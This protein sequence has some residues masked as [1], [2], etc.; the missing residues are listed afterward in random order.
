M[1]ISFKSIEMG[2]KL[3]IGNSATSEIE[4]QGKVILKMTLGESWLWTLFYTCQIDS[5]R[6]PTLNIVLHK[7]IN[8]NHIS[9]FQIDVKH[10]CGS[11]VKAKL[12]RSSFQRI[13][14]NTEPLYFIHSDICDF[15][16]I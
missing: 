14:R 6:E 3:Y 8:M 16:S 13:K 11:C 12:T 15:K 4:G 1:F 10:K 5:G 2:E 7:L 9:T